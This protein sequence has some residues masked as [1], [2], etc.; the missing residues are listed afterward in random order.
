MTDGDVAP[1]ES[2]PS[3][4][5]ERFIDMDRSFFSFL[6]ELCDFTSFVD[7]FSIVGVATSALSILFPS[8]SIVVDLAGVLLLLL[9]VEH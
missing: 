9:L 4:R 8:S 1:I 7:D 3:S 6:V 2:Y 5:Q